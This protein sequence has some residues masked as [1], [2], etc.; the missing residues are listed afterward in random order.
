MV[1]IYLRA[2]L[3]RRAGKGIL[4]TLKSKSEETLVALKGASIHVRLRALGVWVTFAGWL[5]ILT[6]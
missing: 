4:A 1:K 2:R 5:K 3:R 6:Q